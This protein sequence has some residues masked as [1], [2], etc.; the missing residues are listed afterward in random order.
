M[1]SAKKTNP[2]ALAKFRKDGGQ[3]KLSFDL[4][5]LAKNPNE[6]TRN[7]LN[8]VIAVIGVGDAA[9]AATFSS[10]NPVQ[11]E[12]ITFEKGAA[13]SNAGVLADGNGGVPLPLNTFVGLDVDQIFSL[14]IDADANAGI[15]FKDLSE[16]LML[17]EYDATF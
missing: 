8:F 11:S 12:A 14:T 1:V 16:V 15:D 7:T 10:D 4:K 17:V 5:G 13:F 3:L 9:V 2:G 6:T